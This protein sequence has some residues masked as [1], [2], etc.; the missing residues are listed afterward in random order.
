MPSKLTMPGL[1]MLFC[2]ICLSLGGSTVAQPADM[3]PTRIQW[4]VAP[5]SDSSL[6]EAGGPHAT[7]T[8]VSIGKAQLGPPPRDTSPA[9]PGTPQSDPLQTLATQSVNGTLAYATNIRYMAVP[10]APSFFVFHAAGFSSPGVDPAAASVTYPLQAASKVFDPQFSP[11]GN[12]LIFKVGDSEGGF[13]SFAICLWDFRAKK[14]SVI[15]ADQKEY[16]ASRRVYWSPQSDQIAYVTGGDEDGIESSQSDPVR[17]YVYHLRSRKTSFIAQNVSASY[18]SWTSQGTLLYVGKT[19]A[20]DPAETGTSLPHHCDLYE[21]SS[22]GGESRKVLTDA[23]DEACNPA[24][25]PDGRWIAFLGWPEAHVTT[26]VKEGTNRLNTRQNTFGIYLFNRQDHS[27]KLLRALPLH[28][29]VPCF[30]Q[31]MPDNKQLILMTGT[32][33]GEH[34]SQRAEYLSGKGIGQA[35]IWVIDTSKAGEII[36]PLATLAAQDYLVFNRQGVHSQFQVLKISRTGERL[37]VSRSE[38]VDESQDFLTEQKTLLSVDLRTG[39]TKTVARLLNKWNYAV[40]WDWLDDSLPP[41]QPLA[42]QT[43][44]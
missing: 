24:P 35:V 23:S 12:A 5:V 38:Y 25:S 28:S 18:L 14:V 43:R 15:S 27:R 6:L 16:I 32:Y 33:H 42:S 1:I 37:I 19:E 21:I 31:W 30:L 13:G 29:E 41:S 11:S 20:V 10:A 39:Q 9:P 3:H 40:G 7:D 17:L 36:Q 34:P 44:L 2:V 22:A 8:L 4:P 26:N